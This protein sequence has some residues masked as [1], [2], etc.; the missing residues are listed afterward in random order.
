[1]ETSRIVGEYEHWS[2]VVIYDPDSGEIAHTHQCVTTRG[3]THPDKETLEREAMENFSL[4]R[5][6]PTKKMSLLHVDPRSV[7][8]DAHYKVDIERHSLVEVRLRNS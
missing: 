8:M 4:G 2:M 1:M 6:T 3:G 5:A 7:K